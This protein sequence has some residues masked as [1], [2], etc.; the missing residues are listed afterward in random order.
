MSTA[1]PVVVA[2]LVLTVAASAAG[3][4]ATASIERIERADVDAPS[5]ADADDG[6]FRESRVCLNSGGGAFVL[7]LRRHD[8]SHA[9]F[10]GVG[11]ADADGALTDTIPPLYLN[12]DDERI[13]IWRS[14]TLAGCVTVRAAGGRARLYRLTVGVNW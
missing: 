12:R 11:V 6:T 13:W 8:D 1:A 5:L 4:R 14:T 9:A 7:A 10:A 3:Q 2:A